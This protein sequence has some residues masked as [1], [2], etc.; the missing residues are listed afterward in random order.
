ELKKEVALHA[1]LTFKHITQLQGGCTTPPHVFLVLELAPLGSLFGLLHLGPQLAD[2]SC[3]GTVPWEVKVAM[4]WDVAKA[5]EYLHMRGVVHRDL[6]SLNVLVF[7]GH[8]AKVCDFGLARIKQTAS[9]FGTAARPVGTYAWMA[10][11]IV[12]SDPYTPADD[13]YSLG[14]IMYEVLS[15]RVPFHDKNG[16]QMM[17][18][19]TSGDRPAALPP[20]TE[21]SPCGAAALEELMRRCW[22]QNAGKRPIAKD[23][24]ADM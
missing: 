17:R 12:D 10:P 1:S 22:A 21:A 20:L 5:I 23:V 16:V 9:T 3:A 4:V 24:S 8:C 18:A 13:V 14:L 15:G 11:E 2:G 7:A 19:V 6:K